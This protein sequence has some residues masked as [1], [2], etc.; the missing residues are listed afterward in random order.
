MTPTS[1]CGLTFSRLSL[2]AVPSCINCTV[3][4]KQFQRLF[5]RVWL[6]PLPAFYRYRPVYT[7]ISRLQATEWTYLSHQTTGS[8]EGEEGLPTSPRHLLTNDN[9]SVYQI[10]SLPPSSEAETVHPYRT[11]FFV[12]WLAPDSQNSVLLCSFKLVADLSRLRL[13]YFSMERD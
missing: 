6:S 13:H 2:V 8:S 7:G 5:S 4:D 1:A 10:A 9:I 12:C 11:Y 3:T